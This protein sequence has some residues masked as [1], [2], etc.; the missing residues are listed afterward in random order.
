[1]NAFHR[2]LEEAKKHEAF[3]RVLLQIRGWTAEPFGQGQLTDAMRDHLRNIDTA[4]RWMPDIIA[5]KRFANR[6]LVAFIDAKAG[7]RW[8]ETSNHDIEISALKAAEKWIE[9]SGEQCPY[10][11]VFGDTG[12]LTPEDVRGLGRRG[13]YYGNGSGTPF[14]LV[15]ASACRPFDGAFGPVIASSGGV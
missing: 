3:V 12:V 2:R 13:S 11:F 15:P 7:D 14:L 6:T 10:Y 4:V 9:L 1:M 8:K 5:A